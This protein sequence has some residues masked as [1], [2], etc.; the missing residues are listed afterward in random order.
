MT[1]ALPVH[2]SKRNEPVPTDMTPRRTRIKICCISS[3]EE[4]QAA[5]AAGA[6][7]IGLVGDM[8]TGPGVIADEQAREIA[9][10]IPPPVETFLLTSRTRAR[11]IADH[12]RYCGV[13]TVQI[14][15]HIDAGEHARLAGLLGHIRRVQVIHVEDASALD[16]IDVYSPHI[17]A[18]LLDS[19]SPA[20]QELGG[21][22]RTHDWQVSADFVRR[23]RRPVFLAGGLRPD[24]VGPAI[25]DVAPYG[26]DLCTGVRTDGHLDVAKLDAFMTAVAT[27]HINSRNARI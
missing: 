20:A 4:A 21:T 19:G 16:L 1:G 3:P 18:F 25:S 15:R 2:R 5:I 7:A 23:S 9:R 14:V 10:E 8:P 12:V 17:H 13:N 22:G 26:L 6:D 24:N 11:D 27:A